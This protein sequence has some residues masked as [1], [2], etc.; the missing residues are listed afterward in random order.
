MSVA[1]SGS[2]LAAWLP[3]WALAWLFVV[4]M[5]GPMA[6][7]AGFDHS[8]QAFSA[9]LARHVRWNEAGTASAVDYAGLARERPRL[10]AYTTSLSAVVMQE[11]AGWSLVQRRAFLINAYNAF[12][13]QLI[14]TRYPALESIRDL[15]NIVFDSPW[16]RRFFDLLGQRRHLDEIEHGLLRGAP[17]FDEPRIHFAVNCASV[18]CPALRPEAYRADRLDAQLEDQT[19][20]FLRDR[21]RNRFDAAPTPVARIS[22]IFR[23]YR[24]DFEAGHRGVASLE[25]FLALR[26]EALADTAGDR[27]RVASGRFSIRY[28]DY[29]WALN[30]VRVVDGVRRP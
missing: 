27:A 28:T 7:A 23:W 13:L 18:G 24:G 16:K 25:A 1:C 11:Y 29:S 6:Q 3:S 30:D 2:V 20:R 26:A 10:D 9:L 15:G 19:R 4:A 8:H 21:S 5:P 14:L 22:P 17:D 12:T